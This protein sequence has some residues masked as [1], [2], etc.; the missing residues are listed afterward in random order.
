MALL[1]GTPL[2]N[3]DTQDEIYI[4]TAPTIFFQDY[5]AGLLNTPDAQGFYWGLSGT[6]A[7][8]VYQMGCV[9]GV[10]LS[11]NIEMQDIRCD[12]VG[13]KGVIQ[14]L[15]FIDLTFNLKT[16]LPAT[17]LTKILRASPVVTVSG[18]TEQFGFGQPNNQ[19][20]YHVYAPSVYDESAADYIAITLFKAQFVD[21]WQIAFNYAQ[22]STVGVTFRAF[23]D[24][25]KPANQL[26]GSFL[27]SD[28]S[29]IA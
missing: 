15:N 5:S 21:A 3:I 8:P 19:Q 20:F 26:F 4:D 17:H 9:E 23:A 2:G 18:K 1:T 28:P 16:L 24:D 12:T 14:K 10:Q 6:T 11:G 22:P 7:Y 29:A 25:T 27:R 13:S